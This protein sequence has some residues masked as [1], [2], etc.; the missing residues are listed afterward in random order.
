MSENTEI[1]FID[2]SYNEL[3]RIPDGGS[4]VLI[5]QDGEENIAECKYLDG[6]HL[7]LNGTCWHICQFAEL[8]ERNG[9]TVRPDTEQEANCGYR[10]L[11]RKYAGNIVFKLGYNPNAVQKY[12]TWQSYTDNPTRYDWG[13]YWSD[14]STAQTD[15]FRRTDA[16][17]RGISYDHT[18]LIKQRES[19][20]IAR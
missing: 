20:N 6:T 1:R 7:D 11:Q 15:L 9:A 13:H 19:R 17:L 3:F 2:S 18:K 10:I 14:K 8:I 16:K 4:I 12:V 5:H